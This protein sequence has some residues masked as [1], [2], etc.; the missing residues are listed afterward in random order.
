MLKTRILSAVVG[1]PVLFAIAWW[2]GFYWQA[3]IALLAVLGLFEFYRAS[4]REGHKPLWVL[5]YML[6]FLVLGYGYLSISLV[7]GLTALL[8]LSIIFLVFLYPRYHIIDIAVTWI[9]ALYI[10][11]LMNFTGQLGFMAGHFQVII[12]TFLLTWANDTGAYF[13]GTWWGKHKMAPDLS[14]NKTWEGMAGGTILTLLVA[15]FGVI[16]LPGPDL[17]TCLMLGFMAALLG[18]V[19]DLFASSIK[20]RFNIKDFGRLI[21]GHGGILDRFDSFILI[22]PVVYLILG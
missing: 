3:L 15:A 16:M 5:G 10:G 18:P 8:I 7:A 1:I 12:F 20:R 14:P 6:L 21:P 17:I 2:G 4:W 13:A 11:L 22:A 9:G 19:G